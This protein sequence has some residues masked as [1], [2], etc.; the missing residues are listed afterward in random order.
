MLRQGPELGTRLQKTE[1]SEKRWRD[2]CRPKAG[3]DDKRCHY[4]YRRSGEQNAKTAQEKSGVGT[5]P[6]GGGNL[7][8]APQK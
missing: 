5:G 4:L 6:A 8:E 2:Q 1:K 3:G 7:L